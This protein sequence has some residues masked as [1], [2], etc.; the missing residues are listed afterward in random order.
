MIQR[1]ALI[2][3]LA[4]AWSLMFA[5]SLA[6]A[7]DYQHA[8]KRLVE[9]HKRVK[10]AQA[11]LE[12]AEA[13]ASKA[14][15][16]WYP[17][18]T[19]TSSAGHQRIYKNNSDPSTRLPTRELTVGLRQNIWDFGTTRTTVDKA[20]TGVKQAE[21]A[22]SQAIQD[23][24]LEALTS[25]VNLERARRTEEFAQQ[26]VTNI[27]KQ[28]GM[29]ESRVT[30]GGGFSSDVLQSKSQLA[31]AQARL[32]RA[33]GQWVSANNRF[34][35]LFNRGPDADDARQHITEPNDLLPETLDDAIEEGRKSNRQLEVLRLSSEAARLEI[36]RVRSTE[37]YPKVAA[38]AQRKWERN[39]DGLEADRTQHIFKVE[40][41]YQL[42]A[43]LGGMHAVEAARQ[44][45]LSLDGKFADLRDLVEEQVRNAWQNLETAR[46]NAGYLQNQ[47]QIAGEFLRL[48]REERLHGRRSL[49]DVLSGETSLIN[50]QSDAASA[51][52][53]V[54][55]AA[56]ALLRASGLLDPK[57]LKDD[58]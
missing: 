11:D 23:L 54:T 53:D 7:E 30:M 51:E 14:R 43:G 15:S 19:A 16:G 55:L 8:L 28:T 56:F 4:I 33:H 35:A 17:D 1:C 6:T 2:F 46:E 22:L 31:G 40:M 9:T 45:Y 47:V 18:V 38:V 20:D 50:A 26:S 36:E 3:T 32:V 27:T 57:M 44:A 34:R 42:N 41:T 25:Y 10:S 24:T 5:P 48:A 29:E 12:A 39:P 52:A 21:A 37:L 49:I 13:A 58:N